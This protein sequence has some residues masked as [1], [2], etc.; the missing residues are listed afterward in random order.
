MRFFFLKFS[1]V[2]VFNLLITSIFVSFKISGWIK[3]YEFMMIHMTFISCLKMSFLIFVL[4]WSFVENDDEM[5]FLMKKTC[6]NSFLTIELSMTW[7]LKTNSVIVCKSF[8][9]SFFY[10]LLCIKS[11]FFFLTMKS[12]QV[13]IVV[14]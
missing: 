9:V 7:H 6:C 8:V 13:K 11:V 5:W 1:I 12:F 10:V 4:F 2:S 14:F 3:F